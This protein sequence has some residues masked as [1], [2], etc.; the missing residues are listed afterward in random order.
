MTGFTNSTAP[1]RTVY[2]TLKN[3]SQ[4]QGPGLC[5]TQFKVHQQTEEN[6]E[7]AVFPFN[8]AENPR[9]IFHNSHWAL[10]LIHAD[11]IPF[12][13]KD[14]PQAQ[15]LR[16]PV[17]N[18]GDDQL[19]IG[20]IPVTAPEGPRFEKWIAMNLWLQK[21]DW[22]YRNVSNTQSYQE[23]LQYWLNPPDCLKRDKFLETCYWE[24]L[25]G[26]LL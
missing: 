5:F 13:R 14:F 7:S 9:F 10:L 8:A 1:I 25:G 12:L 6:L 26:V 19:A 17:M 20:V 3:I 22:E 24:R 15:W 21:G 23:T 11:E 18:E 4:N 2:E 16:P